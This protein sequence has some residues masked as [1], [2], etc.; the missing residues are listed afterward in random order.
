VPREVSVQVFDG[1]FVMSCP[2]QGRDGR[3][4]AEYFVMQRGP[5]KSD[6][7]L[8][9]IDE[10]F[11]TSAQAFEALKLHRAAA[12]RE[13]SSSASLV[14]ALAAA[15]LLAGSAAAFEAPRPAEPRATIVGSGVLSDWY[16]VHDGELLC[17]S[18]DV[19][20]YNRTIAC[21]IEEE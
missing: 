1:K 8:C 5:H 7:P 3:V 17:D 9:L 12:T 20:S 14:A 11:R 2:R 19:R 15:V 4:V 18:L 16:L 21:E 6:V 13:S 10:P